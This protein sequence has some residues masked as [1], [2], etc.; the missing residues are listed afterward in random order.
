VCFRSKSNPFCGPRSQWCEPYVVAG[1]S[2]YSGLKLILLNWD[3]VFF[4]VFVLEDKI[5]LKNRGFEQVRVCSWFLFPSLFI[6]PV[7]WSVRLWINV[8][9]VR[10]PSFSFRSVPGAFISN[11]A[12]TLD[13][14][15]L[16]LESPENLWRVDARAHRKQS[17]FSCLQERN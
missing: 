11:L 10:I 2:C 14:Y 13:L 9:F 5:L 17:V 12:I 4:F 6:V 3:H 1:T 15:L 8:L 7:L 16:D